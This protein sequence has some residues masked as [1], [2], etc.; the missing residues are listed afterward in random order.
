MNLKIHEYPNEAFVINNEDFYDVDFWNGTAFET[1][2]I[3]GAT[4]KSILSANIYNTDGTLQNASRVVSF[5]QSELTLETIDGDLVFNFDGSDQNRKI[6]AFKS[7]ALNRFVLRLQDSESVGNLGSNLKLLRY[8]NAGALIGSVIEIDRASGSVTLNGQ[9]TMPTVDGVSGDVLTTDGLG[10]A[11]WVTPSS[12]G[13]EKKIDTFYAFDMSAGSGNWN[14]QAMNATTLVTLLETTRLQ[15]FTGT[16]QARG[17]YVNTIL[18]SYYVAGSNITVTLVVTINGSVGNVSWWCGINKPNVGNFS[19]TNRQF[20]N[21]IQPAQLGFP[22]QKI[23]FT[24]NGA[25]LVAGDPI[26]IMVY[27][28]GNEATDTNNDDS[29]LNTILIEQ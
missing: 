10:N 14:G 13:I 27:R 26:A 23:S 18:P 16:G 21:A 25:G 3:S 9:Y 19:N 2:K 24:F 22:V 7:N 1:R 5:D 8:S 28:F 17:C 12:S 6:F 20:L 15:A 11:N 4:L 29:Y